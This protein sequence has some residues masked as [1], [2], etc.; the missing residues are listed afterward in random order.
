MNVELGFRL[1]GDFFIHNVLM[2]R[3][4]IP[5]MERRLRLLMEDGP[6]AAPA[7]GRSIVGLRRLMDDGFLLLNC[8]PYGNR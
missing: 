2:D 3:G 8:L 5:L 6:Q 7:D 1:S 4:L